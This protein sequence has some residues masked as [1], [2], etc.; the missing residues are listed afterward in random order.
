MSRIHTFDNAPSPRLMRTIGATALD[1]PESVAELIANSLD[2]RI[3]DCPVEVTVTIEDNRIEVIDNAAG[4]DLELLKHAIRL[5]IDMDRVK[6]RRPGRM[7]TYGLGMKTAAASLGDRWGI[8]T[9]PVDLPNVEYKV[10]FDLDAY[11]ARGALSTDW[12]VT[13]TERKPDHSGAL[14]DRRSGTLVWVEKLKSKKMPGA[15][16]D[17]LGR[18]FSPYTGT[19][20]DQI[21]V[22][23]TLATDASR[24]VIEGSR[25]EL[26]VVVDAE[27]KWRVHGWVGLDTQTHNRGDYGLHLYRHGQL[28][29]IWNKSFFKAHLMTSR[30]VG[31]AHLDFVP[32]NFNKKGFDVK[33]EAWRFTV[34]AMNLA[35]EP[36]V[37]ASRTMSRGRGDETRVHRAITK[38]RQA[39]GVGTSG[40]HIPSG[41]SDNANQS[42]PSQSGTS[43][44]GG[45][46]GKPSLARVVSAS[47]DR[48][49][50]PHGTA[51][52]V[53]AVD[54]LDSETLPWDYVYD[55]RNMELLVVLNSGAA[56]FGKTDDLEF[57]ACMAIADCI[58]RVLVER[59][60]IDPSRARRVRDNWLH[61]AFVL[62]YNPRPE[63]G[64][65]SSPRMRA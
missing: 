29:E 32:V 50:L 12:S 44:Q 25:Y 33:S 59:E 24:P 28:V 18:A 54:G 65:H 31:V 3:E 48:L 45:E 23:G 22:N 64:S 47:R 19:K 20:G 58:A 9:R 46:A 52:I 35:L 4:M 2:A 26:D 41:A 15:F 30:I 37:E 10:E 42:E 13:V 5:G 7:G 51:S 57:L 61:E 11:E 1:G 56:V 40:A 55:E 62:G 43:V 39:L 53:C 14:G 60:G 17:H 34:K 16:L 21:L 49:E 8:V 63:D 27:N 6:K 38:M 36:A